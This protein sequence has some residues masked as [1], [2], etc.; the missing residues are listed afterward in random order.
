MRK[1]V[2][3]L[4]SVILAL[5][6][7]T[8][9]SYNTQLVSVDSLLKSHPDSAL[10]QLR[11]MSFS[12]EADR[13][14]HTLLLA[15]AANKCY[16]TLPSDSLL[17]EVAEFYD[18][19]G[20]SNEQ[21]RAHYLLGCAYRDLGE[22]PQAL[23]CFHDAIDLADTTAKDCNY[24]LL[25]SVYGQMA[26]IFHK[27]NLPQDEFTA[28]LDYKK[29]ALLSKDTLNYIRGIELSIKALG[30]L[31]DTGNVMKLIKESQ[32]LYKEHGLSYMAIR[33]NIIPIHF[34]VEKGE[35]TEALRLMNEYEMES[36]LFDNDGN[37]A[38]GREAYYYLKGSYYQKTNNL[39][40]AEFYM[41]KMLRYGNQAD[42]YRGLLSIFNEK[43][44]ADS[45]T[46]FAQLY[47]EA[48][49]SINSKRQI[50]TVHQMASMYNY[51]RFQQIAN[52]ES[53]AAERARANNFFLSGICMLLIIIGFFT[54]KHY[55]K[56]KQD[57][58]QQIEKDY[59]QALFEYNKLI[60]ELNLQK[61]KSSDLLK[62]KIEQ[63][64][65]LKEKI[66]EYQKKQKISS[67][68]IKISEFVEKR[69]VVSFKEK[70]KWGYKNPLPTDK[71]W[72]SF[73]KQFSR[74]VP[75][76][77]SAIGRD[78]IL[79]QTELKLCILLLT[80]FNLTEI[81][82]LLD[83]TPQSISNIKTKANLKLFGESSAVT[84]EQNQMK[85]LGMT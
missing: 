85:A 24:R 49:D 51:N 19:H 57:E 39:D 55:R 20:T 35:F 2:F 76:A 18:R 81:A 48:I 41:R 16:D 77:Y 60:T 8:H 12:S 47:E 53:L 9:S 37:I 34:L 22:A 59:G 64:E 66:R 44:N 79:S 27:Q 68:S 4:L 11:T 84:L 83:T 6:A 65:M 28:A 5:A 50:E 26:Y 58:I 74:I 14:Y 69:I 38:R 31:K 71:E 73:I 67:C 54:Y 33:E 29:N 17:R 36:Q 10:L 30:L 43:K 82:N 78:V 45:I 75:S 63:V 3:I 1:R 70:A 56:K 72:D 23:D 32:K 21:V 42:A 7:C 46:K 62:A 61:Q 25:M 15:D 52:K 13:M 40:S 80:G